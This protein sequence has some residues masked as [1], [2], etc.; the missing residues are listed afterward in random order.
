M[1]EKNIEISEKKKHVQDLGHDSTYD[2]C[3]Y[4]T[5][6]YKTLGLVM[7]EPEIPPV[8][9][10]SSLTR[11]ELIVYYSL[12]GLR[13]SQIQMFLREIHGYDIRYFRKPSYYL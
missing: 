10:P 13:I 1:A 8:L 2:T 7:A 6:R 4:K 12:R 3:A 5:K 9:Q 11:D